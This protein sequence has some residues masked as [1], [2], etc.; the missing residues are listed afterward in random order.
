MKRKNVSTIPHTALREVIRIA[1]PEMQ[2]GN[3]TKAEFNQL[4]NTVKRLGDLELARWNRMTQG[5]IVKAIHKA[6]QYQAAARDA[7]GGEAI[8]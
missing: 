2:A 3:I 8:Q 4:R 5:L 7:R 6:D 1:K